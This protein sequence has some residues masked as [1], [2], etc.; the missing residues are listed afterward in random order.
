M[1]CYFTHEVIIFEVAVLLQQCSILIF[2]I[3]NDPIISMFVLDFGR[4][5][6]P[7]IRLCF[8]H[9]HVKICICC[10][11]L[12]FHEDHQAKLSKFLGR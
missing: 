11:T 9:N 1:L 10:L 12:Y 8:T 2:N 4:Q 3:H 5:F 6:I 7:R